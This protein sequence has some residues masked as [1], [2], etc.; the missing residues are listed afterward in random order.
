[1]HLVP[2]VVYSSSS[3]LRVFKELCHVY[4]SEQPSMYNVQITFYIFLCF[5]SFLSIFYQRIIFHTDIW[6][7]QFIGRK[8]IFSF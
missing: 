4:V 5:K 8:Y 6:Q 3:H 2:G 1:M 7:G